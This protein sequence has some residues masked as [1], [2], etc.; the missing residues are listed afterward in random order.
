ME[1]LAHLHRRL[2]STAPGNVQ[3]DTAPKDFVQNQMQ[4]LD[5]SASK[6]PSDRIYDA[7]RGGDQ[8]T[9]G[10]N[11]VS[12]CISQNKGLNRVSSMMFH[13]IADEECSFATRVP[14]TTQSDKCQ[15]RARAVIQQHNQSPEKIRRYK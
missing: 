2:F 10:I 7:I 12:N 6:I 1:Q 5:T 11:S 15:Q 8:S 13:G 3:F 9:I 14:A 4:F